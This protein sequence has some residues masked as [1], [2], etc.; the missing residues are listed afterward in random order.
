MALALAFLA[1]PIATRADELRIQS[2]DNTG[3]L[4]F[5]RISTGQAYRVECATSLT[6]AWT[7][8]TNAVTI[9][10][11]PTTMDCI[12]GPGRGGIATGAVPMQASSMFF[13][14]VTD[15][16]D[17]V[18]IPAGEFVMG[19]TTNAGSPLIQHTVYVSPFYMDRY[20]VT[21]TTWDSVCAWAAT[22][23]YTD[24]LN[25]SKA[26][27]KGPTHPMQDV[28]WY[29]AAKWCNAR[30]EMEGLTP[31]FTNANGSVFRLGFVGN[32]TITIPIGCNWNANGYRLPTEAEWEKAARGGF[33][34]HRFPWSDTDTIQQ[35]RANYR[36]NPNTVFEFYDTNPTAGYH[37]AYTNGGVPYTSPVGA[38]APNGY[39]L[40][41]MAGNANEWCWDFYSDTY[42]A[43]SPNIDPRG[44]PPDA[45]YQHRL[46]DCS[47]YAG[48][49]QAQS[50]ARNFDRSSDDPMN[51]YQCF[52]IARSFTNTVPNQAPVIV[53]GTNASVTMS[54]DGTPTA[55]SRTLH[56]TDADG[57]PIG[58]WVPTQANNGIATVSGRGTSMPIAYQPTANYN[59][60]DSFVVQ[61]Y[62]TWGAKT[63]ITVNV[64]IQPVNDAPLANAQF[65]S[66]ATNTPRAITLTGYDIVEG[67]A[68]T[69]AVDAPPTHGA[70]S[71]TPPN[72]TYTPDPGYKGS[73]SFTFTVNDRTNDSAPATV[74]LWVNSMAA[75]GGMMT[76][77]TANG[78]NYTA[79]IFKTVGS[80]SLVVSAGGS[81]EVLLVAGGGG[82][83][84]AN[85]T[86][87][88]GGGGGAGGLIYTNLVLAAGS[89]AVTVGAGGVAGRWSSDTATQGTNSTIAGLTAIGGGCGKLRNA[90]TS[91]GSGAGGYGAGYAGGSG[92][93]PAGY[94][95]SG[96]VG[97]PNPGG[98]GGG[99]GAGSAGSAGV[100]NSVGGSGGAGR[101]YDLSGVSTGYAG[102]GGGGA[103]VEIGGT[104]TDG[105]GQ[106]GTRNISGAVAGSPNTG[107]GGGGGAYNSNGAVGGSGIVIVR[108]GVAVP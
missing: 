16:N 22:H 74:T 51:E 102:G 24:L 94:G 29:T 67:S 19:T 55:F 1:A 103:Q 87:G 23:A 100:T 81:V 78:T 68:I 53:E 65:V 4:T 14:A 108:Y 96:G 3:A 26:H 84:G 5:N 20:E 52:R 72:V 73:D 17:M 35:T 61:A 58:W 31:C 82:G 44:P 63:S 13:R 75:W 7:R 95:N 30:S 57:D 10:G 45:N 62:D 79:H 59:G 90:G 80:T 83:G 107:G 46:R 76:N 41:D 18:L 12:P 85:T 106:G 69:Y 93:Q 60:S 9:D 25:T 27:S 43:T 105:G 92:N 42:Y 56:A 34:G 11:I 21:K 66:V 8:L 15:T 88:G 47:W 48:S 54:E 50:G 86:G 49:Y 39:G 97:G 64:T 40:Y 36:A 37:P 91:G 104:A 33:S 99:G 77:Y 38:F 28:G 89:Y 101:I 98:G 2:L 6:G 70:L 71:G 32:G